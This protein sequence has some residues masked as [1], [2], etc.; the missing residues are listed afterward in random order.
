MDWQD[1]E[2]K[3]CDRV[4]EVCVLLLPQGKR[5]GA[6]W[7]CGDVDGGPGRSFRVNLNGKLGM[8]KDFAGD[9]GGKS[10]LGLWRA[11]R[12]LEF[13]AAIKEAKGFLGIPD[14]FGG[15]V[16]NAGTG[17]DWKGGRGTEGI[18]TGA[19][20]AN[21]EG[22]GED[23]KGEGQEEESSWKRVGE[24]WRKCEPLTRGGPV[25]NYLVVE[26]HLEE[27]VLEWYGVREMVSY[28]KWVMVF[29]Y[30][31]PHE[32]SAQ[33]EVEKAMRARASTVPHARD[34]EKRRDASSTLK[35][36]A[37]ELSVPTWLK[38]E[39]LE[40]VEG[41]KREWTS[42]APEKC[43]WGMQVSQTAAFGKC[44]HVIICEGEKD[45][46]SWATIGAAELEGG[47][48][49]VSVPFGAKWRGQ[50]Q[51]RPSPNRE[52]LDRCWGWLQGYE[53]VFVAMDS[54]EAGKRAAADIIT[55]VGP[56]R[57]RL[58]ELPAKMQE[59]EA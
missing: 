33:G 44:R 26:R 9:A 58:V 23:R 38:F 41:K 12:K 8:W 45:A 19:N 51:G 1:V 10:L 6:E 29:P 11:V 46:L 18:F 16:R 5:E 31:V 55:E 15:R 43:L 56:R 13:A 7:V 49:P 39:A 27:Q 3:L 40:R 36:G 37:D 48:M 2:R 28:G 35:D 14:D 50:V 53:T 59:V 4:E 54:D 42:K 57:C 20:R 30:Y 21:R 32:R 52:W 22:N 17:A 25:W 24:V 47:V 34:G